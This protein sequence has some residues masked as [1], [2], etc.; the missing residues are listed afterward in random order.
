MGCREVQI[1]HSR[2]LRVG[3][4]PPLLTASRLK[5]PPLASGA[6]LVP[7]TQVQAG[8]PGEE[9]PLQH[10]VGITPSMGELGQR[11]APQ[12][13]WGALT[14]ASQPCLCRVCVR[15][16]PGWSWHLPSLPLLPRC[17]VTSCKSLNSPGPVMSTCRG[18]T[19]LKG[20]GVPMASVHGEERTASVTAV[21]TL[22]CHQKCPTPPVCWGQQPREP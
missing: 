11:T 9:R 3:H 2:G 10:C 5:V 4:C 1:P 13:T 22:S 17:C 16:L 20:F 15:S 19:G 21:T 18:Q 7:L 6:Q 14:A 8:T 12:G